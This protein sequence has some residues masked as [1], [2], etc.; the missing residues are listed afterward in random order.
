MAGGDGDGTNNT[1]SFVVLL[2]LCVS[3][4]LLITCCKGC[5][6]VFCVIFVLVMDEV[7]SHCILLIN[8]LS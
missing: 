7:K 2:L 8:L 1:G 4:F 6:A 5:V 3:T